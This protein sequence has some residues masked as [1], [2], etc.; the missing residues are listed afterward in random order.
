M[1]DRL[2][3]GTRVTVRR[4]TAIAYDGHTGTVQ[5]YVA[6]PMQ[7]PESP[8]RAHYVVEFADVEGAASQCWFYAEELAQ[9]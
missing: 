5:A 8:D 6:R 4:G 7:A 1:S 9:G 3:I 2:L